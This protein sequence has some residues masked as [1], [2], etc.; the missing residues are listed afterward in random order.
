[1]G[2]LENFFGGPDGITTDTTVDGLDV[3]MAFMKAE[4]DD[5]IPPSALPSNF[6]DDYFGDC[7]SASECIDGAVEGLQRLFFGIFI[8]VFGIGEQF[9][10]M[11]IAIAMGIIFLLMLY[12]VLLSF[13]NHTEYIAKAILR[14]WF[15]ML[16]T[17]LFASIVTSSALFLLLLTATA[18]NPLVW[19]GGSIVSLIIVYAGVRSISKSVM[20]M[21]NSIPQTIGGMFNVGMGM[22][23][24]ANPYSMGG[25]GMYGGMGG[26]MYGGGMGG[27]MMGSGGGMGA[28]ARGG[29]G[30]AL[31]GATP[32]GRALSIGTSA[33]SGSQELQKGGPGGGVGGGPSGGDSGGKPTP[34]PLPPRPVFVPDRMR[35]SVGTTSS[36]TPSLPPGTGSD[37]LQKHKSPELGSSNTSSS[38]QNRRPRSISSPN[39][40]A[41]SS[42]GSQGVSSTTGM[43]Q[44][45]QPNPMQDV[46]RVGRP[47]SVSAP[48]SVKLPKPES[49]DKGSNP[50]TGSKN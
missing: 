14:M 22:A 39:L 32:Q 46:A 21:I 19:V 43:Q 35:T 24:M 37:S 33:M 15:Q 25:G 17:S 1:M 10:F 3:A 28:G 13:F 45:T 50:L 31:L 4:K 26:G 11:M 42:G 29:A 16:M 6:E 8:V 18:V 23:G 41:G 9:V 7:D 47:R 34:P 44:A 49:G 5:V 30:R 36:Q 20:E 40:G 27:G 2:C 48:P 12:A 38:T